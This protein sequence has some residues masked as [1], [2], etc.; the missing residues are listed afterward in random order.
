MINIAIRAMIV[1]TGTTA[2]IGPAIGAVTAG[3]GI[4]NGMIGGIDIRIGT[5]IVTV[6]VMIATAIHG[7]EIAS[8]VE[9]QKRRNR[10]PNR[11]VGAQHATSRFLSRAIALLPY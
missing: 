8:I 7:I 1:M 10:W 11:E 6:G 9:T 4:P 3:I 5:M 2:M